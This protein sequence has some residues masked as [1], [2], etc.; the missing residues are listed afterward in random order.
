MKGRR[1]AAPG[2]R[3]PLSGAAPLSWIVAWRYLTGRRS[4]M[5][6][7]TALAALA[8][9]TLGVLSMVVAMAL[10]TG[11]TED[12]QRKLIGLQGEV[13]ATPFTPEALTDDEALDEVRSLPHV[14]RVSRVAYGEGSISGPAAADGI[15]VVLRGV[16]AGRDP[17]VP[18]PSVLEAG[19]DGVP[20]ALFGAEL[21]EE[22]GAGK[23][24]ALRLVV[25]DF[26]DPRPRFRYRSVRVAGPF[27]SGFA[28]FDDRWI[29]LD[30][31]LLREI[32]GEIGFD[33]VELSLDDPKATD[34]VAEALE[35]ILGAEWMVERWHRLN[36]HL[37]AALKLQET[38]LFLVLGL[39]VVVATFDVAATLLILVR[40]RRRD[41]CV[42]Q[43]LGMDPRTLR[44]I[45]ISYG[46]FLGGLG[47]VAGVALGTG[48]SWVVT[49]L[50]L[51]RFDPEVAR[52]YF[53]DSVPFRVEAMDV[54]AIVAFT[55]VVTGL[56]CT[57]PA[58][59]AARLSPAEAVR[60]E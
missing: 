20:G 12:L 51:V 49:E 24:D 10:M 46:L 55:M 9:T 29:L 59:R 26:S 8:A 18:D 37:F 4:Q 53:I 39:I 35:E 57:L 56:A 23:G 31:R 16:E 25:L 11:Y 28:E 34:R 22:L 32:R 3:V 5:L 2:D 30:R 1:G 50:E 7:G 47:T 60:D 38:A 36:R 6:S 54:L 40:E 58:R 13:I 33:V 44:R 52:I 19:P 42:L 48:I 43:S 17:W 45:F 14:T 41:V 15:G 27:R 21:L